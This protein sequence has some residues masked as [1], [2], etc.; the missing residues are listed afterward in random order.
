MKAK[1]A[2][3]DLGDPFDDD[4]LD[5]WFQI[6]VHSRFGVLLELA[7]SCNTFFNA[8]RHRQNRSPR[9]LTLHLESERV[10]INRWAFCY[11]RKTG[12]N[13]I[14]W[15]TVDL[16]LWVWDKKE[17]KRSMTFRCARWISITYVF[18]NILSDPESFK[19]K[20]FSKCF[21][22]RNFTCLH[23]WPSVMV[24][25]VWQ[26]RNENFINKTWQ[27]IDGAR[28]QITGDY[29]R[30]TIIAGN[31]YWKSLCEVYTWN[32]AWNRRRKLD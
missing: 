20:R 10:K 9:N 28:R 23:F 7:S 21:R 11:C 31:F 22:G 3:V 12:S 6:Q 24:L 14:T 1:K 2:T 17:R 32:R 16:R 5:G 18:E 26:K 25:G 8:D 30:G 4:A 13:S 27:L 29:K 19:F 15:Y